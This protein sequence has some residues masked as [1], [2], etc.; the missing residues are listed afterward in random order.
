M[1]YTNPAFSYPYNG[2]DAVRA[3]RLPRGVTEVLAYGIAV[4]VEPIEK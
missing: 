2:N 1:S 4:R 3:G